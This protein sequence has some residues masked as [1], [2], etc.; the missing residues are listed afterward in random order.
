MEKDRNVTKSIYKTSGQHYLMGRGPILTP[1]I[2]NRARMSRPL[3]SKR[4]SKFKIEIELI[5]G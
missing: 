4:D 5:K 3:L 2:G 1:K